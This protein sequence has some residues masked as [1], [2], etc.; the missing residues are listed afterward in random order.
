MM[1]RAFETSLILAVVLC[2]GTITAAAEWPQSG[3]D[4]IAAKCRQR[5]RTDVPS[6][7]QAAYCACQTDAISAA[8]PWED[9]A[10]AAMEAHTKDPTRVSAKAEGTMIA[11]AMAGARCLD[12]IV[13][14]E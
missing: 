9:F 1:I 11:A 8:I 12:Q 4:T 7:Y 13:H 10:N 3:I 2:A 6:Q 5:P 14:R